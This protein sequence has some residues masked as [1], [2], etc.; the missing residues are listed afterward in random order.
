VAS[1]EAVLCV[2][3][4]QFA[5]PVPAALLERRRLLVSVGRLVVTC[6]EAVDP[7]DERLPALLTAVALLAPVALLTAVALLA[8]V[9]LLTDRPGAFAAGRPGGPAVAV[10]GSSRV[11]SP[12]WRVGCPRT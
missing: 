5:G 7:G 3:A 6:W 2:D 1:V 4:I 10:R 11:R 8:P 12:G 9:A